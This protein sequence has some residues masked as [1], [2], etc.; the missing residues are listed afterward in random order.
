MAEEDRP[1]QDSNEDEDEYGER[2]YHWEKEVRKAVQPEP[3]IF[4]PPKNPQN[5]EK[6]FDIWERCQQRG[7]RVIV[8]L[9]NIELSPENP[10]YPGG[11]WHVEGQLVREA[12]GRLDDP[13]D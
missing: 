3:G 10:E 1:A 6:L 9:A 13:M 8:K 7:I 12:S 11:S 4:K 2:L 5:P